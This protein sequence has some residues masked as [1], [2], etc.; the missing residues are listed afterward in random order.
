MKA[1]ILLAE[2]FEECEALTPADLLMRA[3]VEVEL[4]SINDDLFVKGAHGITVKADKLIT[5]VSMD[6]LSV[7]LL[8]G[9]GL[10]TEILPLPS[11]S[12]VSYRWR[13]EW[14]FTLRRFAL[15]PRF[16][17]DSGFLTAV[18]SLATPALSSTCP[19]QTS[20]ET[21]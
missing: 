7:L 3:G 1:L 10:G 8:P 4:V 13:W 18:K 2:G 21:R 14:A 17:A 19:R 9:G 16:L 12:T 6:D 15:L 11:P 20:P 5:E